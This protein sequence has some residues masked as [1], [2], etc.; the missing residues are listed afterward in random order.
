[1]IDAAVSWPANVPCPV[2]ASDCRDVVAAVATMRPPSVDTAVAMQERLLGI[3]PWMQSTGQDLKVYVEYIAASF[4]ASSE[5][6][7]MEALHPTRG[8][9][10]VCDR[11]PSPE[12]LQRFLKAYDD[13][14]KLA[15]SA[16]KRLLAE[17]DRR[18]AEAALDKQ[19]AEEREA[20]KARNGGKTPQQVLMDEVK[21]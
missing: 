9:A 4:A 19:I 17:M 15:A 2:S 6:A 10:S 21:R 13:R 5:A 12:A 18:A 7:G 20:F 16:A 11:P 1:M 3:W 14:L 8:L